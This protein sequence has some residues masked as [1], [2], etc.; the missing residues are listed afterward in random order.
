MKLFAM[1]YL[2]EDVAV[3]VATLL[4]ARGLDVTTTREQNMLGRMDRDQL[5]YAASLQRC[6]LT[7]NRVDFESLY[8]ELVAEARWHSG[9]IIASRRN[10]YALAKDIALLLDTVAA[11]E[12]ENQ[13][14][15]I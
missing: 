5:L 8:G 4:Q 1:L 13:L 3:L 15:Y 2:D 7:H 6:F 11:D 10:P 12:V 14:L 9:I